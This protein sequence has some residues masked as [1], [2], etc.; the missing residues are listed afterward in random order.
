MTKWGRTGSAVI[1]SLLLGCIE[2]FPCT[3]DSACQERFGA[4]TVCV[5]RQPEVGRRCYADASS[6]TMPTP[7]RGCSDVAEVIISQNVQPNA[8]FGS[9]LS[10]SGGTTIAVGAF[11]YPGLSSRGYVEII[12][13]AQQGSPQKAPLFSMVPMDQAIGNGLSLHGNRALVNGELRTY[14]MESSGTGWAQVDAS[15]AP[16]HGGTGA[17]FDRGALLVDGF[18]FAESYANVNGMLKYFVNI[19][20]AGTSLATC[21]SLAPSASVEN[22]GVSLAAN[23]RWL[24]VGAGDTS[25]QVCVHDYRS[26]GCVQNPACTSLTRRQPASDGFGAAVA[27]SGGILAIGAP[28]QTGP[29]VQPF[30]V[31]ELVQ[32]QWQESVQPARFSL[33]TGQDWGKSLAIDGDLLVV[34]APMANGGDGRVRIYQWRSREWLLL[35]ELAPPA[36][37]NPVLATSSFGKAVAVIGS[38]IAVG[39]PAASVNSQAGAGAVVV[40]RC[41]AQ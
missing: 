41:P 17:R 10:A 20:S 36:S 35:K 3:E 4:G 12:S 7:A 8:F 13:V 22:F 40:Y 29:S 25:S 32:G 21:T 23:D 15:D 39:A 16:A 19:Y 11:N 31:Y 30:F 2:E 6:T 38:I 5:E 14:L 1:A 27:M 34:G 9:S 24:A 33:P 26:P 28:S 18:A 37:S